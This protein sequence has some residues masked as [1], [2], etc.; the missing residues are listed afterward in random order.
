M[1]TELHDAEAVQKLSQMI[2]SIRT[3]MLTTV[4]ADGV[5]HS[6]PMA[7]QQEEFDGELWFF[8]TASSQMVEEL[9]ESRSVNLSY[10]DPSANRFVSVS[11]TANVFRD[12]QKEEELWSPLYQAWFPQGLDDPD[13]VLLRVTVD[14]AEYWDAP[15]SKMAHIVG[16]MKSL[17][18]GGPQLDTTEHGKV[19]LPH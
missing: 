14:E 13:L 15:T 8:T 3:A 9:F 18:G 11:G 7:T 4:G 10:A 5:L 2:K 19:H 17:V 1:T 6:R 12:R 16:F